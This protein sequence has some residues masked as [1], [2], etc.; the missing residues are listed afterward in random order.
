MSH[1]PRP[2]G[3]GLEVLGDGPADD[4][5]GPDVLG[6]PVQ[7]T[8]LSAKLAGAGLEPVQLP[9]NPTLTVAPVAM[10]ALYGAL[11]TVTAPPACAAVP[12]NSWVMPCPAVKVQVS[13]QP[14]TAS[15]RLV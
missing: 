5:A 12:F 1:G 10:A 4:G 6:L 9:L 8:P 13:R 11:V 2:G 7:V 14:F 3:G 15:P